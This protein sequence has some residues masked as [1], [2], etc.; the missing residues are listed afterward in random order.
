[1]IPNPDPGNDKLEPLVI[2]VA[3]LVIVAYVAA[4]TLAPIS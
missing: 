2:L 4:L 1:M 3:I